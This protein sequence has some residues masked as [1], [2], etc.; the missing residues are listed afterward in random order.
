MTNDEWGAGTSLRLFRGLKVGEVFVELPSVAFVVVILFSPLLISDLCPLTS[1]LLL[2]LI[3][4][5]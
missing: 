3:I 1:D 4:V 2:P 5:N